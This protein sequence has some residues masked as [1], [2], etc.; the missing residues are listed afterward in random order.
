V[1]VAGV[2][3]VAATA[4]ALIALF[5]TSGD[6]A[7]KTARNAADRTE[8]LQRSQ[9]RLGERLDAL[10]TRVGNLA[11][12]GD[13]SK[14]ENRLERAEKDAS[15]AKKD[16]TMATD[17]LTDLEDRVGTLEDDS[18]SNGNATGADEPNADEPGP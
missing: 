4:V 1:L 8:S 10:D 11:P 16:A 5:D 13:V 7:S 9:E 12:A 14:L 6:D 3:A 15:A 2:W 18:S 17:N